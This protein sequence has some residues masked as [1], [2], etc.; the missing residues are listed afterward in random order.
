[1]K[2]LFN[3]KVDIIRVGKIKDGLGGYDEDEAVIYANMPCRI[4][5]S[6]GSE[7]IQFDKNT[8]Y[9][10]AKLFCGITDVTVKDRI[11]YSGVNYEIINVSNVDN[12]NKYLS[13]EIKLIE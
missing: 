4:N 8:Y 11:K 6:R 9:R 1:M 2:H 10:D 7:R 13:L 3:S 5:W 12:V